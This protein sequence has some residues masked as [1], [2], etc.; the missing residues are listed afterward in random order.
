M[1]G[2]PSAALV[3]IIIT[4]KVLLEGVKISTSGT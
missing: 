1:T 4:Q 3:G 2:N